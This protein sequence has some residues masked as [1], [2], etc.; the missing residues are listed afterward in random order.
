MILLFAAVL[1]P[2]LASPS[3]PTQNTGWQARFDTG[4]EAY[5]QGNYDES[6]RL[7]GAAEWRHEAS[8]LP[9]RGWLRCRIVSRGHFTEG[10]IGSAE[11]RARRALAWRAANWGSAQ[12]DVAQSLNTFGLLARFPGAP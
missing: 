9:T 5:Q 1:D 6:A 7:L 10:R 4:W 12:R 2:S 3:G 8:H 11:D